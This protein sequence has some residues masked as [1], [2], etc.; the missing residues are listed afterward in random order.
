MQDNTQL[1]LHLEKAGALL[2]AIRAGQPEHIQSEDLLVR[3]FGAC[4]AA[5][6]DSAP[7]LTIEQI[8]DTLI[9]YTAI[10]VL[11]LADRARKSDPDAHPDLT[12]TR[13]A[14]W[15]TLATDI[16][17]RLAAIAYAEKMQE[18]ANQ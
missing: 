8:A 10:T 14:V 17:I 4:Q 2:D 13:V 1:E 15:K 5:L 16:S 3:A 6:I 12:I 7:G 11:T 18:G 9:H